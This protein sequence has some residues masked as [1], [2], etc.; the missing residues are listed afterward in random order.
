MAGAPRRRERATRS[1]RRRDA[2][3]A[4]HAHESPVDPF[5]GHLAVGVAHAP[6]LDATDPRTDLPDEL[7]GRIRPA[8]TGLDPT[9]VRGWLE[10]ADA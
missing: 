7:T 2:I 8:V 3:A 1:W 6:L 4:K 10:A 9:V 5:D